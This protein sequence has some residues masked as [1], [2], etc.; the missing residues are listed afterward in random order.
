MATAP[1][2]IIGDTL[3][4]TQGVIL[5]MYRKP[6][7]LLQALDTITPLCI[8]QTL[9]IINDTGG[10]MVTFPLHKGDDSFMSDRQFEK[11]LLAYLKQFILHVVK[12]IILSVC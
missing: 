8:E 7:K 6:E 1:F 4:G 11:I 10:F 12:R 9:N 5:D 3:R 2:D